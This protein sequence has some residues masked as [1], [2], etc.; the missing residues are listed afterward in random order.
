MS[1]RGVPPGSRPVP[2]RQGGAA[3]LRAQQPDRADGAAGGAVQAADGG[4]A[5][6]C[7][8]CQKWRMPFEAADTATPGPSAPLLC[9]ASCPPFVFSHSPP[10]AGQTRLAKHASLRPRPKMLPA[11]CL[12]A[13][14]LETPQ[15]QAHAH[16]YRD[17][18]SGPGCSGPGAN[19]PFL[20]AFV[21]HTASESRQANL[22]CVRL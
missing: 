4:A 19:A 6:L 11:S 8:R 16:V 7:R 18:F 1:F 22:V 3:G 17:T 5:N 21:R 9:L 13:S 15:D 14:L 20:S 12:P 2:G 10:G